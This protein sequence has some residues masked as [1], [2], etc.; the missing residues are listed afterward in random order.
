MNTML[1]KIQEKLDTLSQKRRALLQHLDAQ[2]P[3]AIAYKAGPDKWSV[4]EAIEHLVIVEDNFLNQVSAN[5]P[6]SSLDPAARSPEK[7]EVVLKV[8][9]RDIEVDV[10]HESMEPH[11]HFG[12]NE[13]LD[14]WDGIRKKM[15]ELLNVFDSDARD[16]LIYQH[17][18]AGPLNIMETLEFIEV[19]FD[20]HVRHI[21]RIL[22]QRASR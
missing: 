20:N 19:H 6:T 4:V 3:E 12:L 14:K 5:M 15:H 11:G 18:Y 17:P 7:Y 22:A 10:P 16:N 13:L 8:M 2:T 9:K 21:D 1:A